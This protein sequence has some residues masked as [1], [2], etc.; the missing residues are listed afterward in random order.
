[1][2]LTHEV[3]LSI[4]ID[5][6]LTYYS[7]MLNVLRRLHPVFEKWAQRDPLSRRASPSSCSI[8]LFHYLES[9]RVNAESIVTAAFRPALS[10]R[11]R[12]Y[13]VWH[14]GGAVQMSLTGRRRLPIDIA[15]PE[16]WDMLVK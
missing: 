16:Q 5:A 11:M 13:G 7:Q 15:E 3:K 2:T 6:P 4:L 9:Y 14:F 8:S 12:H 1:M 10:S